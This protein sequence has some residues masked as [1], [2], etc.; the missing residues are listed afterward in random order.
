M[1]SKITINVKARY[2]VL[3]YID[4]HRDYDTLLSNMVR[5]IHRRAGAGFYFGSGADAGMP[6]PVR[7]KFCFSISM[8]V[9]IWVIMGSLEPLLVL[10]LSFCADACGGTN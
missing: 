3:E 5:V 6:E 4:F 10:K 8:Q 1:S 7:L 2:N 9:P